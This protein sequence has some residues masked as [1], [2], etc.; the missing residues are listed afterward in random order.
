MASWHYIQVRVS[1]ARINNTKLILT[2]KHPGTAATERPM[3]ASF[4]VAFLIELVWDLAS[5]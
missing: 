4:R 1:K 2:G 3:C 5:S